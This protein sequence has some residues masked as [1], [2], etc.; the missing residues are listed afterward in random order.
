MTGLSGSGKTTIAKLLMDK[1]AKSG[2]H[3]VHLDGDIFRL[4]LCCDLDYTLAG[5]RENIRRV[6][7]VAA[8]F[9]QAGFLVI[10]SFCSPEEEGRNQAALKCEDDFCEVYVDAPIQE[11]RRRDP[12]GLYVM[13]D[14]GEITNMV[15]MDLKYDVP[16][17]PDV[18]LRTTISYPVECADKIVDW[19]KKEG[20]IT[21]RF[22]DFGWGI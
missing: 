10:V 9:C 13:A 18:H 12:S 20:Y 11:C 6:S 5:R 7:E 22:L 1:I 3:A 15:G 21:K 14:R 4:G 8:M 16:A 2:R 19:L 17:H